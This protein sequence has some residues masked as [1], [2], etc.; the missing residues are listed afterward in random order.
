MSIISI[1]SRLTNVSRGIAFHPVLI[2]YSEIAVYI[3]V[4]KIVYVRSIPH[5]ACEG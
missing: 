2:A 3:I 4:M 5:Y 1:Q